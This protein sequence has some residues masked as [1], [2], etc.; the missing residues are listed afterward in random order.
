MTPPQLSG[1]CARELALNQRLGTNMSFL[2]KNCVTLEDK[3]KVS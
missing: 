1:A 3:E 2:H